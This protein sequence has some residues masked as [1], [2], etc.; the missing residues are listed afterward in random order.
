L[1]AAGAGLDCWDLSDGAMLS[2][3]LAMNFRNMGMLLKEKASG[4]S[5]LIATFA[6]P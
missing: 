4:E 3:S 5:P 2:R 6:F 1:G